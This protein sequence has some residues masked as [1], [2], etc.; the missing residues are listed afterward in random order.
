MSRATIRTGIASFFGGALYDEQA[1]IYRPTPLA[2][3]GL[4]GVRPYWTKEFRD[5]DYLAT[6]AAGSTMGAVMCVHLPSQAE[7]R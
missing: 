5:E 2:A 7:K 6:L 3:S 1:R 4:A